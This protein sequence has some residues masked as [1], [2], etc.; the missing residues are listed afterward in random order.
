M[1]DI[2][3]ECIDTISYGTHHSPSSDNL[4]HYNSQHDMYCSNYNTLINQQNI[5][6][7]NH[8]GYT[9]EEFEIIDSAKKYFSMSVGK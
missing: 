2:W 3:K 5:T 4:S 1:I 6:Q 9:D 7:E 8:D